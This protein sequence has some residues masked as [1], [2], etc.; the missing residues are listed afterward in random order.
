MLC[1]LDDA[2]PAVD[3]VANESAGAAVLDVAADVANT[4]PKVGSAAVV[5]AVVAAY[6]KMKYYYFS[7]NGT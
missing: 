5:L 2:H 4:D 6:K 3:V 1:Q 7:I